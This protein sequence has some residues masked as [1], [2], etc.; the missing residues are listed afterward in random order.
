MM[1]D[2][3]RLVG[4]RVGRW[5]FDGYYGPGYSNRD[6]QSTAKSGGPIVH[7]CCGRSARGTSCGSLLL[8]VGGLT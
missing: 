2:G 6:A 5:K 4:R 3:V 8:F 1:S 7:K